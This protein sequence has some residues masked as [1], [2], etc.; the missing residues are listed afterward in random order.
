MKNINVNLRTLQLSAS[1]KKVLMN[2]IH[3]NVKYGYDHFIGGLSDVRT[4]GCYYNDDSV[5]GINI[6]K[7]RAKRARKNTIITNK[8]IK[9]S[10]LNK[11]TKYHDDDVNEINPVITYSDT[12]WTAT[13]TIIPAVILRLNRQR[14]RQNSKNWTLENVERVYY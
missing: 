7:T 1:S 12:L 14:V 10:A 2:K 9:K 6:Q 13:I 4:P 3:R 11:I 5:Y 8:L